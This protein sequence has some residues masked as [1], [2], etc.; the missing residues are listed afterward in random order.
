VNS[1]RW[2]RLLVAVF[3]VLVVHDAV[4]RGVRFDGVRPDLLLGLAVVAALVAGPD[5]GAVVGFL[6]G[7]VADLF[8]STPFG[9]SALVWCLLAYAVGSL[10][11]TILPQGRLSIPV[12]T[13]VATASGEVVYAMLATVVGLRDLLTVHL[14]AIAVVVG[15]CNSLL[16]PLFARLVRWALIANPAAI[17]RRS[18]AP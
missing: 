4:L 6:A 11:T 18:F 12:A 16:S 7:L 3:A 5:R 10:Q 9:L 14:L 17:A 13:L 15:L 8:V 2:A 1:T